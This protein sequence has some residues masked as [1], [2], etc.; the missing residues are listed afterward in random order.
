MATSSPHNPGF[1]DKEGN[2][3][4]TA[5]SEWNGTVNNKGYGVVRWG[6]S[7]TT[8]QAIPPAYTEY[9]GARLLEVACV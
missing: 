1:P 6:D 2:F 9:I 8:T 5:C 7:T 3:S 4:Q